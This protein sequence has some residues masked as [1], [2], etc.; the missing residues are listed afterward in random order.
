M[1]FADARRSA[2]QRRIEIQNVTRSERPVGR[3]LSAVD[4]E[5]ALEAGGDAEASGDVGRGAA[6]GNV[7]NRDTGVTAGRKVA[8]ECGEEPD[9]D[10]HRLSG[11]W[12]SERR[13]DDRRAGSDPDSR[14][15]SSA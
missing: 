4:Q 1:R 9:F 10:A 13:G 5:D 3:R 11:R 15:D 14:G 8:L 6:V 7:D 12:S 2:R